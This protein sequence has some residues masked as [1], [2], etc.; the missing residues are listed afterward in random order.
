MS[1]RR[2]VGGAALAFALVF[3]ALEGCSSNGV[4]P[5]NQG[6]SGDGAGGDGG[7]GTAPDGGDAGSDLDAG[8]DAG[9][10]GGSQENDGGSDAGV[11]GGTDAGTLVSYSDEV[12]PIFN[13][14]CTGCHNAV[15]NRGMLDL[16][17]PDSRSRLVDVSTSSACSAQVPGVPRVTPGDTALSMLWRK[18]AGDAARCFSP[19]PPGG[20]GLKT[21]APEDFE[22]LEHWIQQGALDN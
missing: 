13:S 9:I 11:D 6:G 17:A 22:K 19:M 12:Q 16:S 3:G 7:T 1:I 5:D 14:R 21:I 20:P 10:D 2:T 4:A 8:V 18:A 15:M